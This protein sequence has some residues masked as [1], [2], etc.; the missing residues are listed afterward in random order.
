[1]LEAGYHHNPHLKQIQTYIA[2]LPSLSTTA[3]KVL[4]TCNNPET[5]PNDLNR[6]I[7]LDLVLT[8]QVLKLINSAYYS[9]PHPI[10]SLTRAIIMLGINT[11]KNLVLSFA[12]LQH[13]RNKRTF[14]ALCVEDFWAHSLC[15][16]VTAKCLAKAK[17]V[18]LS[19]QEEFFV[20]GLLHDL[21]KIPLNHLFPEK[22]IRALNRAE[23]SRQALFQAE[24]VVFGIDHADIGG[25]IAE[26][27][28]LSPALIQ[29]LCFHHRPTEAHE[30]HHQLVFMVALADIFAQLLQMRSYDGTSENNA[31]CRFLLER[32]GVDWSFLYDLRDTVLGEIDKAKVFLEI[33]A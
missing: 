18:S 24:G 16:G 9:L 25:M 20:S 2:R 3:A 28:Q 23:R 6:V 27:W 29:A 33:A 14:P 15:V 5:S 12:I 31:L 4:E 13:M 17:G 26:K 19:D 30:W 22:Y 10:S 7:S 32:V 11:V 21:G 8:G 1:M